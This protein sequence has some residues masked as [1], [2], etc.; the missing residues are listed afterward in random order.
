MA[1]AKPLSY[2]L[3]FHEDCEGEENEIRQHMRDKKYTKSCEEDNDDEGPNKENI[4]K[5]KSNYFSTYL[6]I[7]VKIKLVFHFPFSRK[8]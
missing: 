2:L 6:S 1:N 7:K 5:T 8:C 4:A 3:Y